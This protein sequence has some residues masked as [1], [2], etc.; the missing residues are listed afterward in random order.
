M[1][2]DESR[3]QML[4]RAHRVGATVRHE[5]DTASTMDDARAGAMSGD[6]PGTAYVAAAQS[7]GRGRLGRSWV[8]VPG[9]GLWVTYY[10]QLPA[11]ALPPTVAAGLA[12]CD[13]I[14]AAAGLSCDL[15]WPNDVQRG[16]RKLCGILTESVA[17]AR[18]VDVFM[19]IGINLRTPA[20]MPEEVVAIATSVEQE[21][22]PAPSREVMLAAL[23]SALEVRLAQLERDPHI[24]LRD[25]RERLV[26]LGQHV[27]LMLP[28]GQAIEGE[29][30]D[31]EPDGSLILD[32]QGERRAFQAGE[33]TSTRAAD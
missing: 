31:V 11:D 17:T 24:A 12:V 26:T 10:L 14:E 16:G 27:R 7:A 9:A 33:V 8:S 5:D 3:Y 13:A 4:R 19:G 25:W 2:F 23:S 1:P 18:A 32:V 15:K 29:A 30:L 6:P 28:S 21:G 20:D 22:R